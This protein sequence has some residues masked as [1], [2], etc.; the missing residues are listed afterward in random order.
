MILAETLQYLKL[1]KRVHDIDFENTAMLGRQAIDCKENWGENDRYIQEDGYSETLF[2]CL[3]AKI[4]DSFDYSD[5]EEA[6][7]IHDMNLPIPDVYKDKYSFVFDGGTL[8]H[9]FNF[10]VA[11]KNAMEMVQME[12]MLLIYTPVNNANCHG[13]YQFS[14][15]L[16][17]DLL[18]NCGFEILDV[19]LQV[20]IDRYNSRMYRLSAGQ[21]SHEL[22]NYKSKETLVFILA[23][24]IN[25]VP[26][27]LI[28]QQSAYLSIWDIEPLIWGEAVY[29]ELGRELGE[30]SNKI[31]RREKLRILLW[32]AGEYCKKL[33]MSIKDKSNPKIEVVA[34]VDSN[35]AR[36]GEE[37]CGIRIS[38]PDIIGELNIDGIVISTSDIY[39]GEIEET[40]IYKYSYSQDK[41]FLLPQ[42]E[43]YIGGLVYSK[44]K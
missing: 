7:C 6:T 41:I 30:V 19:T 23:K 39:W 29:Y 34:L 25:V 31:Y 40:I 27:V 1:M 28:L 36:W 11:I 43:Y 37:W 44:E 42:F 33:L 5:Y 21:Y 13:L 15:E 35:C 12:G 8:E 4:V 10:P 14:V 24:K 38:N 18:W 3:G 17:V 22:A 9:V 2:K 16:L 26:D 20:H 32:G